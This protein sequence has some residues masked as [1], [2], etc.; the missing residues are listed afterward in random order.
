MNANPFLNLSVKKEETVYDEVKV[1]NEAKEQTLDTNGELKKRKHKSTVNK[2][3]IQ[4][5][6]LKLSVQEGVTSTDQ[7]ECLSNWNISLTGI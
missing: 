6:F 5:K 4:W 7:F 3:P 1:K 2:C